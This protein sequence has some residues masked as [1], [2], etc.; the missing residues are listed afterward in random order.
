MYVLAAESEVQFSWDG[1]ASVQAKAL[2]PAFA[3]FRIS[4]ALLACEYYGIGFEFAII[5]GFLTKREIRLLFLGQVIVS[6]YRS[7]I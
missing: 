6:R 5:L 2:E 4:W 3:G 1:R 7:I